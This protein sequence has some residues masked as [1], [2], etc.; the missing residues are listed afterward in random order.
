MTK[1]VITARTFS[2]RYCYSLLSMDNGQEEKM[3]EVLR[4]A[5]EQEK[6]STPSNGVIAYMDKLLKN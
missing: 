6:A 4:I 2:R 1:L 3:E 5:M